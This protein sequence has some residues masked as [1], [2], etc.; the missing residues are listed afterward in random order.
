MLQRLKLSAPC[1]RM[2]IR[3]GHLLCESL[4][5]S[6]MT[7]KMVQSFA[8]P[9]K[10][11]PLALVGRR[12]AGMAGRRKT[13]DAL[14]V[15]RF[16]M[17]SSCRPPVLPEST[18]RRA[19]S[20]G[21]GGALVRPRYGPMGPCGPQGCRQDLNDRRWQL[22]LLLL[23]LFLLPHPHPLSYLRQATGPHQPLLTLPRPGRVTAGEAG[24]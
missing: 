11:P 13:S 2:L 16:R 8:D 15:V 24:T 10:S 1:G 5:G 20:R 6:T 23:L 12:W 17:G 4:T 22:L 7:T 19:S 21:E 18:S 14:L 3:G 9:M